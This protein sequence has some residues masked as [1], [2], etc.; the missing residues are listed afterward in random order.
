MPIVAPRSK[1]PSGKG[2]RVVLGCVL[3]IPLLAVV[4]AVEMSD[5][6][7]SP[8][9]TAIDRVEI[10]INGNSINQARHRLDSLLVDVAPH[11][12]VHR[13]LATLLWRTKQQAAAWDSIAALRPTDPGTPFGRAMSAV[14]AGDRVAADRHFQSALESYA[15]EDA[16]R[17]FVLLSYG[18]ALLTFGRMPE[19]RATLDQVSADA[20]RT[21]DLRMAS[22][23]HGQL[24]EL[25]LRTGDY[26]EAARQIG[27]A[28]DLAT[29]A[30]SPRAVA[31]WI[32]RRGR[33]AQLRHDFPAARR[34]YGAALTLAKDDPVA[35]ILTRKAMAGL[36]IDADCYVV[37]AELIEEA[38]AVARSVAADDLTADLSADLGLVEYRLGQLEPAR[39]HYEVALQQL[40]PRASIHNR[41]GVIHTQQGRYEEALASYSRGLELARAA[42]DRREEASILGHLGGL[43]DHLGDDD[44]AFIYY[45]AAADS[46][47]LLG[48]RSDAAMQ[49]LNV[50]SIHLRQDAPFIAD[51]DIEL[52]QTA[53][54]AVG[55]SRG[56]AYALTLRGDCLA[57]RGMGAEAVATYDSAY[58]MA[59][60]IGDAI[61]MAMAAQGKGEQLLNQSPEAAIAYFADVRAQSRASGDPILE[62]QAEIG[63]AQA[64]SRCDRRQ[65]AIAHYERAL[66]QAEGM[67]LGIAED[68]EAA[69]FF[70]QVADIYHELIGLY[71]ALSRVDSMNAQEHIG[72]G[73]DALERGRARS[74]LDRLELTGRGP[75]AQ[76]TA[77]LRRSQGEARLQALQAMD[78]AM[79]RQAWS[80]HD[81]LAGVILQMQQEVDPE[82]FVRRYPVP[83]AVATV[84]QRIAG[85]DV[86]IAFSLGPDSSYA[87]IT[88]GRQ[89][90][91]AV[92]ADEETLNGD[93][94]GLLKELRDPRGK[95]GTLKLLSRRLYD[96]LLAPLPLGECRNLIVIPDGGLHGIPFEV[97]DDGEDMVLGQRDVVYA[98]S[99]SIWVHLGAPKGAGLKRG[100]G[101]RI[102]ALADPMTT[103]G[104][105]L[106]A[107]PWARA[108]VEAIVAAYGGEVVDVLEREAAS[109]SAFKSAGGDYAIV[110]LAAHGV[111]GRWNSQESSIELSPGT[112]ED[113]HLTAGE[114]YDLRLSAG[115]V[116][117]SGCGTAVGE[118]V[119]GEGV[120]GLGRAFLAAGAGVV[121]ASLW[122][123]SDVATADLMAAF[124]RNL[125]AAGS[126]AAAL[127]AAKMAAA[128]AD[129]PPF[130]WAGFVL[131]G[132]PGRAR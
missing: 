90:A 11:P 73:F 94:A 19:A 10:D 56:L 64:H 9:P 63:L 43:Y 46:F 31:Q 82:V 48:L 91:A 84:E 59:R 68:E 123:V 76:G 32:R 6:A 108:E 110:H 14:L 117:L 72:M 105:G 42:V 100:T 8:Y 40:R 87:L 26:E 12:A 129:R 74:L 17:R 18:A 83:A 81:S 51:T 28:I 111:S 113:G 53:L 130:E 54:S 33:L 67:R 98:P 39:R 52:A 20:E 24:G 16:A 44:R 127:R 125:A 118:E 4:V 50:A 116:V 38:L 70:S 86:L 77:K 36:E 122:P 34:D 55:D 66:R 121:M 109:E 61:G 47:G 2:V 45:A 85:G 131:I 78:P 126:P 92:L 25:A 101:G 30:D 29:K 104:D 128:M 115:L 107:L 13:T 62:T 21:G 15:H 120:Y 7:V 106:A 124:Y 97:L 35:E 103:P 60:S 37:A 79:R 49:R 57:A 3:T 65:D 112:A 58:A 96:E 75:A 93:A 1:A 99:A 69:R 71:V 5:G 95:E 114:V 88:N 132:N 22:R 23:A 89:R 80:R 102:L 119:R 41:L 27:L